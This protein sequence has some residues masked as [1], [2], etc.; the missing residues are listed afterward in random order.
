MCMSITNL[1]FYLLQKLQVIHNLIGKVKKLNFLAVLIH[2]NL[3]VSSEIYLLLRINSNF[4]HRTPH[5]RPGKY[6]KPT[7]Q[8]KLLTN[9]V[10]EEGFSLSTMTSGL[11]GNSSSSRTLGYV[12]SNYLK[13]YQII[14][15]IFFEY[16]II[17]N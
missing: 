11:A 4:C 14:F 10:L 16:Q 15:L 6:L 5:L 9:K 1:S 7:I 8:P 12:C 2:F 17:S 13:L 3:Q